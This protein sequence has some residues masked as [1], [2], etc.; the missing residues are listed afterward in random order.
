MQE[1]QQTAEVRPIRKTP[2]QGDYPQPASKHTPTAF[3]MGERQRADFWKVVAIA[4]CLAALVMAWAIV[5]AG[6]ATE[7][8]M[9]LDGAGN[10]TVGAL[11]PLSESKGYFSAV[12]IFASNVALQ[13]S[14][15][16]LDLYDMVNLYYTP[17]AAEK[18]TA[19]YKKYEADIRKRNL[20][21]KP[22]I[23]FIGEPV[24]A[25]AD[26]LVEVRGRLIMAGAYSGKVFY[27]EQEFRLTLTFTRNRNAGNA[28]SYPWVVDEFDLRFDKE[29][30]R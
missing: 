7:K 10:L 3:A 27:D 16:G 19:D 1:E 26:R 12:S 8:I 14:P 5:Q 13:R 22:V 25:A 9:V 21:E 2:R 15:T 24:A 4:V 23:E 17:R 6:R 20:Q 29:G 30:R 11:E 18:L 28:A